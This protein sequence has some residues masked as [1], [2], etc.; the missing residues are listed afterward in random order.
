MYPK[1][2][3]NAID[4]AG[5]EGTE[6][7]ETARSLFVA[8]FPNVDLA[9]TNYQSLNNDHSDVISAMYRYVCDTHNIPLTRS[10]FNSTISIKIRN[11]RKQR[12][13]TKS[14]EQDKENVKKT[15]SEEN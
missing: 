11:I 10:Q 2:P 12:T 7:G 14:N 15:C 1:F 8:C 5:C 9:L 13:K 4:L 6:W 3:L